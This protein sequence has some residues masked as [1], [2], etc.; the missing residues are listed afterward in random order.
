MAWADSENRY[1]QDKV[2]DACGLFGFIDTTGAKHD[3]NKVVAALNSMKERGNG[4]GAGYA[5]YGLYPEFNDHYCF[6]TMHSDEAHRLELDTY[7]RKHFAVVHDEPIP[8][9]H[10]QEILDPPVVWRYFLFPQS[11]HMVGRSEE[12]Y[13]VHEV[14]H[15]NSHFEGSFVVSSGKNMGIFKGVGHPEAIAEFYQIQ[16][17]QAYMWTSHNRFPTNTPGWWGGAHPFGLLDWSVVHNGEI[18]SYGINRRYI[19]QHGYCCTMRTDTEVFA[20]A[21]D[22]LVRRHHLPFEIA[23]AVFASPLWSDIERMSERE[24]RIYRALRQTYGRLLMNGPFTII[25][26]K[27][28]VMMGLG[29]RIRLRPLVAGIR[30]GTLYVSSELSSIYLVEPEIEQTW[31]P[32]GGEPV[33][34]R[35]GTAPQ[36]PQEH[37]QVHRV[38]AQGVEA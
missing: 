2:Y 38:V 10:V 32:Q 29:D 1:K 33:I 12:D 26:A 9:K 27:S 37:K 11:A 8:H 4:L 35:L 18:S 22:L 17:Y 34:G 36:A 15:I 5:A 20:Y 31:M 25:L 30:G 19:E 23:A 16:N 13:I 28:G 21:A 14:M 7:L 3:G 24:Q 6:H